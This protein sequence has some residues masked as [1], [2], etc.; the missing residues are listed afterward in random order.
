MKPLCSICVERDA[1]TFDDIMDKERPVCFVCKDG[2]PKAE[3]WIPRAGAQ[4]E[5]VVKFV[6]ERPGMTAQAIREAL[7]IP[8]PTA[9]LQACNAFSA[10][11]SRAWKRGL[12]ERRGAYPEFTYWPTAAIPQ[13]RAA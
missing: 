3:K 13:R 8:G 11:L 9:D 6:L 10:A 2:A 4:Q 12:L 7:D 5:R 1:N